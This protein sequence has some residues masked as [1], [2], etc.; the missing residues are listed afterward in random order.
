M[1]RTEMEKS[2]FIRRVIDAGR[3]ALKPA[4]TTIRF[5]LCVMIPVSFVMLIL[6]YSGILYYIGRFLS[7]LMRFLGL[8]G[9]S[10]LAL[11]SSVCINIYSALAVIATLHLTGRELTM[12]AV[13]CFLAHNFFVE[14]AVMKKTG[15]SLIKM[16]L[17]RFLSAL[18]AAWVLNRILPAEL[19]RPVQGSAAAETALKGTIGLDLAGLP[20]ALRAWLMETLFAILRIVPIVLGIMYVQKFL[21]EFGVMRRVGRFMA[22]LMNL[23]GLPEH[24]GYAW[25]VVNVVGLAYGSAVLIEE[26]NTGAVSKSDADLLN[27]YAA[28]SHSHLEDTLLFVSIGVPLFWAVVPRLAMGIMAVWAERLRRHLVRL[29]YQVRVE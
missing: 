3:K 26:V 24:T 17:V 12:L 8:P 13:M 1:L 4:F 28:L 19:G 27:H 20:A 11:I 29:S 9:E 23:F 14:C 10:A 18:L 21:D 22:P 7:P 5:L 16:A 6:N 2:T 25:M 15:S